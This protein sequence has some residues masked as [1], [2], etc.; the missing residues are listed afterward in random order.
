MG[1]K[2]CTPSGIRKVRGASCHTQSRAGWRA[3]LRSMY[4]HSATSSVAC[5]AELHGV[6]NCFTIIFNNKCQGISSS[7]KGALKWKQGGCFWAW[8]LC[9]QGIEGVVNRWTP[10]I[11]LSVCQML[12]GKNNIFLI[13]TLDLDFAFNCDADGRS[14][15]MDS[16]AR[17]VE[18]QAQGM[19]LAASW[20]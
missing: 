12:L 15:E 4:S 7:A 16:R 9:H 17:L 11:A 14:T 1:R 3:P 8:Q 20:M 6:S 10:W 2:Q 13:G 18:A 19:S 5:P